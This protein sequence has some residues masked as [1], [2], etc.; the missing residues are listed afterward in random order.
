MLSVFYAFRRC[1]FMGRLSKSDHFS[2]SYDQI[3][4][5]TT[6]KFSIYR[7]ISV[8]ITLGTTLELGPQD[9]D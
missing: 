5:C 4:L 7:K 9:L 8:R 1:H 6:T 3:E 2:R